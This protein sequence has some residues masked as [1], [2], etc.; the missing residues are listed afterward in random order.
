MRTRDILHSDRPESGADSVDLPLS[1]L[2]PLQ[3]GAGPRYMQIVDLLERAIGNGILRSGDR[4]PAQRELAN[5]LGVDLTTVT[6]AYLIARENGTIEARGAYGTFVAKP[7]IESI[8]PL[9][10]SMNIPPPP[11]GFDFGHML[12][13]GL[14]R[15]LLQSNVDLL[16]TYHLGGGSIADRCAGAQ[17]LGPLFTQVDGIDE[18]FVVVTPGAQAA[19]ATLLLSLTAHGD[20]VLTEPYGYPGIRIAAEQLGRRLIGVET[21]E[22]G[23]CPAALERTARLTGARVLY[24][25]P[26]LHNPTAITM[27]ATRRL[28]IAGVVR[29][30]DM[31]IIEDDPYSLLADAPPPPLSAFAPLHAYY[32]ATLSKC[33]SPGLRS[34]YVVL[35]ATH[36][37]ADFIGKLRTF[38]LM[39][40]PLA[41]TLV[42]EWIQDGTAKQLLDAIR[43]EA[44]ARQKIASNTLS[45]LASPPNWG[46]D[47]IHIW[48]PMPSRWKA[49]ELAAVAFAGGGVSVMPS[50]QFFLAQTLEKQ[51]GSPAVPQDLQAIRISLGGGHDRTTL[52]RALSYLAGLVRQAPPGDDR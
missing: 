13:S 12:R 24:I 5:M 26:T 18:N 22:Y 10:L 15:V 51:G 4:L 19:L 34:A 40:P 39:S 35:P 7:K 45:T 31:R 16:M 49:E 47:G 2:S 25:N 20:A 21:D 28:E 42:T 37:V 36:A 11:E 32:V 23:M 44:R 3:R 1:W 48:Y 50:S 17:W 46:E 29:R 6:R 30:L 8:A 9:D 14:S 41:S 33:L 27:P 52:T 43:V 38:A